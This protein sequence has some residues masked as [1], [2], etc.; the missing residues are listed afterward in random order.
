MRQ[1]TNR[2]IAAIFATIAD[3]LQIKGESIHRVLAYSRAA[4]T[5]ADLP[6][7]LVTVYEEGH[8]TDLPNIGET[9]AAKIEELLTT[10]KLE[11]YDR[12]AAEVPPRPGR[13]AEGAGCGPQEGCPVLEGA[14][15]HQHR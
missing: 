12:L 14:G 3:M 13:G 4:E 9:L 7:D 1:M 15:R 11:F 5:I 6:R 2:E 8:L 10:G